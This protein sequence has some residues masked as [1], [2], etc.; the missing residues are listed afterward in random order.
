MARPRVPGGERERGRKVKTRKTIYCRGNNERKHTIPL[1]RAIFVLRFVS[2]F[3]ETL[4]AFIES[5]TKEINFTY[6]YIY[7][8]LISLINRLSY[9]IALLL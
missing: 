2:A 8:R 9:F 5:G 7:I 1:S 6:I 3:R 4:F